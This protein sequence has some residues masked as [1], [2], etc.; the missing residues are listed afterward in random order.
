MENHI[1]LLNIRDNLLEIIGHYLITTLSLKLL[2]HFKVA[3]KKNRY[4][5]MK[6]E[7]TE[8]FFKILSKRIEI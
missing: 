2:D 3:Q 5:F 8:E 1:R 6:Q 7:I 4:R